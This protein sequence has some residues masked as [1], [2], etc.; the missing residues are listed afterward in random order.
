MEAHKEKGQ[1]SS[2]GQEV[3]NSVTKINST[4]EKDCSVEL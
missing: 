2:Q 3:Q 4:K 1:N